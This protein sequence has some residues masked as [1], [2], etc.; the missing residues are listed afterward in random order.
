MRLKNKICAYVPGD[1]IKF[2]I[3][4]SLSKLSGGYVD[5]RND[6]TALVLTVGKNLKFTKCL[7]LTILIDN[8]C[9]AKLA[10]WVENPEYNGG[11]YTVKLS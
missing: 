6:Q 7:I 10:Y 4:R 5:I 1:C 9:L 2:S 3:N 11:T 8:G